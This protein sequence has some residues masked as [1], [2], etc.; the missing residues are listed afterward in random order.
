MT[1][2]IIVV[3]QPFISIKCVLSSTCCSFF[4]MF[5]SNIFSCCRDCYSFVPIAMSLIA[6]FLVLG[7]IFG[8][9]IRWHQMAE[10]INQLRIEVCAYNESESSIL[11]VLFW[12]FQ[13][14]SVNATI[15]LSVPGKCSWKLHFGNVVNMPH[16]FRIRHHAMHN[17]KFPGTHNQHWNRYLTVAKLFNSILINF[18]HS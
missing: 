6:L 5:H 7:T 2:P 13:A 16:L 15:W 14:N 4:Q 3:V 11:K 17:L 8:V 9:G 18:L 12:N 10:E 1:T